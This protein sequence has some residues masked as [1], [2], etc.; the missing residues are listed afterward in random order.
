M[1]DIE[2]RNKHGFPSIKNIAHP[3]AS[4]SAKIVQ[5]FNSPLP[6]ITILAIFACIG[7]GMAVSQQSRISDLTSQMIMQQSRYEE[8]LQSLRADF[9]DKL[10][11]E[12]KAASDKEREIRML[13][14]YVTQNDLRLVKLGILKRKET[15]SAKEKSNADR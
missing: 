13:E 7:F 14:Y 12:R 9:V 11:L 6:W 4:L 15:W 10:D 8:R 2:K 1:S 3:G 5:V